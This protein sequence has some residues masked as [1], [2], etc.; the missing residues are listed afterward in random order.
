MK[1]SYKTKKEETLADIAEKWWKEQGHRVPKDRRTKA[2]KTC[3]KN[4]TPMPLKIL[5]D[6]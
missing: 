6:K 1:R 4:G 2:W 3:I 5:G